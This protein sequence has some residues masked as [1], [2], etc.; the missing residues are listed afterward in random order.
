MKFI[1]LYKFVMGSTTWTYTSGNEAIVYN[2]ET[3]SKVS[4][5]RGESET[6]NELSKAKMD[7]RLDVLDSMAQQI[8]TV[9]TEQTLSLT[10]YVQDQETSTT[11]VAWKGRL[12]SMKP[13][14]NTLVLTFESVF[15]SLRRPGLRAR[16]QKICRHVL[17]GRGCGLDQ[18]DFLVSGRLTALVGNVASVTEA[19]LESDGYYLGGMLRAPNGLYGFIVGHTGSTL[20][21]Q[22]PLETLVSDWNNSGYGLN[23][24]GFYGGIPVDIF[25]GC[26]HLRTTCLDKFNNL[27]NYGGF[28]WIPSR[29]P[30]DGSSIV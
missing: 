16:Y 1:E 6:R 8:L 11:S 13:T 4:L 2:S 12:S 19:A 24:G 30:M 29:N 27:D 10:L 22:R 25:P 15:T 28:P 23:Y 18:D 9:F 26:D 3:Y 17:Y 14:K 21:L 20:T 7:V 5:G